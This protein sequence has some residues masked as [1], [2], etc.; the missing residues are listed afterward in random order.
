LYP[1][2]LEEQPTFRSFGQFIDMPELK[3]SASG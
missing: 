3:R 1:V 2:C